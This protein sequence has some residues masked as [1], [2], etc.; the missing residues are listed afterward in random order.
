MPGET[1]TSAFKGILVKQVS[2]ILRRLTRG[3]EEEIGVFTTIDRLIMRQCKNRSIGI[4]LIF[5]GQQPRLRIIGIRVCNKPIAHFR[6][7]R[8]IGEPRIGPK[9]Q[10]RGTGFITFAIALLACFSQFFSNPRPI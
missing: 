8:Y 9:D 10:G 6:A 5:P 3:P 7:K 2:I 4:N 1:A